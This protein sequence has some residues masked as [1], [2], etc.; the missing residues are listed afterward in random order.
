MMMRLAAV[1]GIVRQAFLP[2]RTQRTQ[3]NTVD[4]NKISGMIVDAA[5]RVHSKLGPGLLESTYEACL[6]YELR[7]RGLSV[8][9]QVALP[10]VYDG[11]QLDDGYRIDLLV[12]E[13]VIV[14]LKAITKVHPVHD[15]QVLS[16]LKL[17]G[18]K[19]GLMIN[20]HV[21]H[22]KDGIKRFVNDI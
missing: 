11:I 22:L 20:F 14:D 3:R 12:E 15:A 1:H 13:S 4:I 7:K 21:L 16:Y 19:L 10:I 5:M 2:Q 18:H 9:R 6:A 8:R 17:S